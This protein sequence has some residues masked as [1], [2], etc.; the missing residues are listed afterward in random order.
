[1]LN[2]MKEQISADKGFN[3]WKGLSNS[4]NFVTRDFFD[5]GSPDQ[6]QS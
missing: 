1:M 6:K 3:E 5:E 4:G 2:N